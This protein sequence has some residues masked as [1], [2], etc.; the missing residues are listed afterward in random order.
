LEADRA[1]CQSAVWH[2]TASIQK[3]GGTVATGA[4]E[5]KMGATSVV[6]ASQAGLAPHVATEA[7]LGS[8]RTEDMVRFINVPVRSGRKPD[9]TASTGV[10]HMP[11]PR[12][13]DSEA[14]RAHTLLVMLVAWTRDEHRIDRD[15]DSIESVICH[16]G[17][18]ML[19][20]ALRVGGA[21]R[22]SPD[23]TGALL[24]DGAGL[25][26]A[27]TEADR[28]V[29]YLLDL[30]HPSLRAEIRALD[31]EVA[32]E[33]PTDAGLSIDLV[34]SLGQALIISE[35]DLRDEDDD[36]QIRQEPLVLAEGAGDTLHTFLKHF[37]HEEPGGRKNPPL[38][39]WLAGGPGTGRN[40]VVAALNALFRTGGTDLAGTLVASEG[41][42]DLLGIIEEVW[43]D[44]R[45]MVL[46]CVLP[47]RVRVSHDRALPTAALQA[48]HIHFG[49]S[50][51]LWVA[52]LEHRLLRSGEY[53]GF[54]EKFEERTGKPWRGMGHRNPD[55]NLEAIIFALGGAEAG[56]RRRVSHYQRTR[57]TASW[58]S[59]A[60]EVGWM[61]FHMR[62]G[63][64]EPSRKPL[65]DAHERRALFVIDLSSALA[66]D[67]PSAR[68]W[69]RRAL[70]GVPA[71]MEDMARPAHRP[72]W[73]LMSP[74]I[75]QKELSDL[76]RWRPQIKRK[77][78]MVDL[79]SSPVT[80]AVGGDLLGKAP[81]ACGPI[82]K[83]YARAPKD[84]HWLSNL[85]G[86][87]L[88]VAR[89]RT[90][91]LTSFPFLPPVLPVAQ[92]ILDTFA[93]DPNCLPLST[94]VRKALDEQYYAPPD[95]FVSLD[96]LLEPIA[97]L[98]EEKSAAAN[99]AASARIF[100]GAP[101]AMP[102][103]RAA[104][105]A[106]SVLQTMR[107]A[108]RVRGLPC[109][110][111]NLVRLMFVRMDRSVEEMVAEVTTT[112]EDLERRRCVRPVQTTAQY[113]WVRSL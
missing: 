11:A 51:H 54:V 69:L 30:S 112:L 64:L 97:S 31:Q 7:T 9:Y 113:R 45:L 95:R 25:F 2:T 37:S 1:G 4:V 104:F 94:L 71:R 46:P 27:I 48:L 52:R 19:A 43:S 90:R 77:Q 84:L 111:E 59:L 93:G 29:R 109:S 103:R 76:I 26:E 101:V 62:P 66:T 50:P 14:D 72:T 18:A 47:P 80:A 36:D 96:V 57:T 100:V 68:G 10:I 56:A 49:L 63:E 22:H 105:P 86:L 39:A 6:N 78:I 33:R 24:D 75:S 58:Q 82:Y 40:Q 16:L 88:P 32:P 81:E 60:D 98:L 34:T 92:A 17:G 91:V 53:P 99:T 61:M 28:A 110:P 12:D 8:Q 67:D 41:D 20:A 74:D 42:T 87:S 44:D 5:V 79:D 38:A 23:W 65:P 108:N 102:A 70:S 107:W 21:P 106:D 3:A 73:F 89:D 55:A 15:D 85:D 83:L 13:F 35:E